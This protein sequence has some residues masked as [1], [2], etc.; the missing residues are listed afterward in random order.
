VDSIDKR[1]SSGYE[2]SINKP[3]EMEENISFEDIEKDKTLFFMMYVPKDIN[4]H[5]F[6][7]L[8]DEDGQ[9]ILVV[10]KTSKE[11]ADKIAKKFMLLRPGSELFHKKE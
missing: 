2:E 8:T 9:P 6:V 4:A 7:L 5:G 3:V 11:I 1:A 10:E